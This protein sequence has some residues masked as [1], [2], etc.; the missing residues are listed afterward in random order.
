MQKKYNFDVDIVIPWVDGSD[1][2]WLKEKNKYLDKENQ[3]DVDA[4]A[5]RYRDWDNVQYIFR[6]IEKFA[7]WV[8]KVFF[9]TCGQKPSWLNLNNEKLVW[10]NHKDYIP[11][12]YLPTFSANPIELNMHRI[13]G[14]SEHFIYLNDDFFFTSNVKKS[15]F[16]DKNGLP[17][18]VAMEMPKAITGFIFDNITM[19]NVRALNKLFNKKEVKKKHKKKWYSLTNPVCYIINKFYDITAKVGWAGFYIKHLPAPFLKSKIEKCWELFYDELNKTSLNKFRSVYDVNQ[20]LF[21][22]YLLC[23]GEFF[24]DRYKR[25]GELLS[26]N[27]GEKPNIGTICNVL[28]KQKYKMVCLSD[29]QITKFEETKQKINLA[30]ESILPSKSNFEL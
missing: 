19:N 22:E 15:D 9:I 12:E 13:E 14:L 21:T 26:L 17:K 23:S 7:P 5:N 20:Y 24:A 3:I 11:E 29:S 27:D 18:I 4:G 28:K 16:F 25:D 8:R 6:G 1:K 30:F 2:E 10:V